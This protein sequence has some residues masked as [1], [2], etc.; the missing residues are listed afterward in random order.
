MLTYMRKNAGSWIVK[1]IFAVII[2]VFVF[3]YGYGSK[4]GPEE[5]VLVTVGAAKITTEQ[6]RKAY[7]NMIQRYQQMYQNQ[8]NDQLA[9]SLGLQQNLLDEMIERELM[10]QEAE[11]RKMLV[12]KEEI[13][14]EV[15]KQ[16]YMQANGVFSEHRYAAVLNRMKMTAAE[17]EQQTAQEIKLNSMRSMITQAVT[18]SDQELVEVFQLRGEKLK[19]GRASCRERV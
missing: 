11:R 19:I 9:R 3:F 12:S 4:Q 8:I 15:M 6:Y 18:I 10:L 2:I 5:R 16:P 7:S 1:V 17:Y 14:R 13:K